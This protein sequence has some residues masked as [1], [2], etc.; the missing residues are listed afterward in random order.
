MGAL[1]RAA[2]AYREVSACNRLALPRGRDS[3]F[4]KLHLEAAMY[5]VR[6]LK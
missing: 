4:S 6:M 5:K 2:W 1:G 3:L